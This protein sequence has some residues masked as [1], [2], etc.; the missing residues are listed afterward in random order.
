M[1]NP[2]RQGWPT[3]GPR[4]CRLLH[5]RATMTIPASVLSDGHFDRF[6][7]NRSESEPTVTAPNAKH[8]DPPE[9]AC[10]SLFL[11]SSEFEAGPQPKTLRTSV[12]P[13]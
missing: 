2:Q 10:R 4:V 7:I 1:F 8:S 13:T 9:V 11:P 5:L 6:K 3:S 12:E